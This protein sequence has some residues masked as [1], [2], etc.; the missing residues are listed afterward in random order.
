VQMVPIAGLATYRRMRRLNAWTTDFLPNAV[1]PSRS[2]GDSRPRGHWG[3][4]PAEA[5]LRTPIGGWIERWEMKRKVNRFNQQRNAHD[6][7]AFCADRC[8]GHFDGHGQRILAAFAARLSMLEQ[9][10]P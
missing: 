10:T 7:A 8:K 2:V 5:I 4:L 6:E 3:R 1:E 9:L